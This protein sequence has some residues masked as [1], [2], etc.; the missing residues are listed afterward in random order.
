MAPRSGRRQNLVAEASLLVALSGLPATGKTTI[1]RGICRRLYGVHIRIDAIEQ[2]LR[3]TG[4]V[5]A[6]EGYAVGNS[7]AEENLRN[8][9]LVV[10]DCVNP[11]ESSRQGWRDVARRVG[12]TLLEIEIIRSDEVDHKRWATA[13]SSD[14][15]GMIAPAWRD[16]SERSYEPWASPRVIIDTSGRQPDQSVGDAIAA[17]AGHLPR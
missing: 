17:I 4:I 6:T 8:G 7:L 1:A 13:R 12:A 14:I 11:C 5:V 3:R 9:A 16:I 10:A 15:E 2:A